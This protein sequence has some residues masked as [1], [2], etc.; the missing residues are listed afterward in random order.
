MQRVFKQIVDLRFLHHKAAVQNNNAVAQL[1]H[2]AQVMGDKDDAGA[3]FLLQGAH[4]FQNLVL[5]GHIQGGGG[6]VRNQQV[7]VVGQRHGDHD[8]LAH[9]AGKFMRVGFQPLFGFGNTYFAEQL[10]RGSLQLVALHLR[11]VYMD[12]FGN[13]FANRNQRIQAGHGVLK[14]HGDL[15]AADFAH[16]LIADFG[17]VSAF[18][19]NFAV[20]NAGSIGQQA[21]DGHGSNAFA[22]AGLTNDTKDLALMHFKADAAHSL[23]FAGGSHKGGFQILYLQNRLAHF[24]LLTSSASGPVHHANHRRQS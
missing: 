23:H 8:A 14:H 20:F 13:L 18:K 4:L 10:Q 19:F 24:A 5:D 2:N 11:V 3:V 15:L 12:H 22:A 21:Q 1:S 6:L 9:T 7:G 17:Q 16:L